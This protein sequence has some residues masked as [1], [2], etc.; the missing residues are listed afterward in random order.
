MAGVV[1]ESPCRAIA[2]L[3][4]A[5]NVLDQSD[6]HP[7]LIAQPLTRSQTIVV[8]HESAERLWVTPLSASDVPLE[9]GEKPFLPEA[10]Q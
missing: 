7:S 10:E 9:Y 2:Y 3:A 4:L 1:V 8:Q 6:C 5:E